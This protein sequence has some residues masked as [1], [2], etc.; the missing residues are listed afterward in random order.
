MTL[1]QRAFKPG[2]GL[3]GSTAV[4]RATHAVSPRKGHKRPTEAAGLLADLRAGRAR[5]EGVVVGSAPGYPDEGETLRR[6]L[7][8]AQDEP[9]RSASEWRL[10]S[11]RTIAAVCALQG[12]QG[13]NGIDFEHRDPSFGLADVPGRT[14]ADIHRE[15]AAMFA[16][17]FDDRPGVY[18]NAFELPATPMGLT[19]DRQLDGNMVLLWRI[20][21]WRAAY[22]TTLALLI[23]EHAQRLRKCPG[24]PQVF[25]RDPIIGR[26]RP[27]TH[28]SRACSN[29]LRQRRHR[30]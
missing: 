10:A 28:C 15:T 14:L 9:Q 27:A 26:G 20:R 7:I 23:H 13:P 29:R 30:Q 5:V 17:L 4:H 22:R 3:R 16:R 8:W 12:V 24:C 2:K 1:K 19:I 21:H 18:V 11:A 25:L 6:V